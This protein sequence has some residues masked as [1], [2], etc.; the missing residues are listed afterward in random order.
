MPLPTIKMAK[1]LTSA[2]IMRRLQYKLRDDQ[3]CI[4]MDVAEYEGDECHATNWQDLEHDDESEYLD[5]MFEGM[6]AF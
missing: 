4:W 3:I 1:K 5:Q 2:T 6:S